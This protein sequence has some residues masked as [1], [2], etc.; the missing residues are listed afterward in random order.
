MKI[1]LSSDEGNK[2]N[3]EARNKKIRQ[4]IGNFR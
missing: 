3:K 1:K 2:Y 4:Q